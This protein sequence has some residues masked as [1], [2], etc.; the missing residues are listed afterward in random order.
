MFEFSFKHSN[1]KIKGKNPVNFGGIIQIS[2]FYF[3]FT[4]TFDFTE[5]KAHGRGKKNEN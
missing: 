2:P 3:I 4:R 1:L 5:Q